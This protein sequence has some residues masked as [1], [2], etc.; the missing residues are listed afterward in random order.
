MPPFTNINAL[1]IDMDGVLWHGDQ[2]INGLNNFFETIRTL[3]IPFILATNNASLTSQQYIKKLSKMGVDVYKKEILTS[4]MA[5]AHYLSL[6][7]T[8]ETTSIFVIGESG[9]RES[10]LEKGFN[11]TDLYEVNDRCGINSKTGAHLVVCGIDR[12]ISW[13]KLATA[14]L[15]INAGAT[16]I[17]TNGDTSLPTELGEIQGN[18]AILA[19]L[20]AAT[21]ITPTIIGKPG[22][23]IYQQA[24]DILQSKPEETIAI[25]DRLDTDILGAIRADIRSLL[26]LTGVSSEEDVNA[27]TFKPTWTVDNITSI[28]LAL[29]QAHKNKAQ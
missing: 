19:A 1:I 16:F 27:S 21:H 17:G 24:M 10:L 7:Y 29:N 26:V 14:T 9:I 4:A 12:N 13:E 3:K 15:N 5:T 2:P 22:P 18:G 23:I 6:H 8:P 25:G 28:T 20:T 11:L